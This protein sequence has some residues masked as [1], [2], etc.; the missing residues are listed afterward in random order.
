MRSWRGLH[1]PRADMRE[2]LRS[3]GLQSMGCPTVKQNQDETVD[4][5]QST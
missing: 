2:V 4:N 1:L 5:E 3:H